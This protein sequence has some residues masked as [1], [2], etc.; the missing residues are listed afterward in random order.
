M[1]GAVPYEPYHVRDA[2]PYHLSGMVTR[3]SKRWFRH[4]D[5]KRKPRAVPYVEQSGKISNLRLLD[6]DC[7]PEQLIA[8]LTSTVYTRLL[9]VLRKRKAKI[10]DIKWRDH[11]LL[12]KVSALY[13]V[14]HS[15]YFFDRVLALLGR[16]KT[17][18]KVLQHF[19]RK[20][21]DK[22]WFVYRQVCLQTHWLTF[23]SLGI[24]DKSSKL[25]LKSFMPNDTRDFRNIV[26]RGAFE[27]ASNTWCWIKFRRTPYVPVPKLRDRIKDPSVLAFFEDWSEPED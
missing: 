3:T 26:I 7:Y 8:S 25:L 5:S 17:L 27:T 19:V 14:S 22:F 18:S 1:D 20:L 11:D 13:V 6:W 9:K 12:I 10:V 16:W 15:D 2:H 21:D 23:R 24:R 4:W